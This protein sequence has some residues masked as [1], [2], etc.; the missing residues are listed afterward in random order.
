MELAPLEETSM[1]S[2]YSEF[3]LFSLLGRVDYSYKDKY[4][5][6]GTIRR[7][8]SS[9]LGENNRFAIFPSA[10]VAWK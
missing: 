10:A 3:S 8:G 7:D 2:D 9:R 1:N 6:T 4:L 5:I